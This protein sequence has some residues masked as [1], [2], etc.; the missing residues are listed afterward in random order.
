MSRNAHDL[1]AAPRVS[2]HRRAGAA[3]IATRSVCLML[4]SLLLAA[5]GGGGGSDGPTDPGDGNSPRTDVPAALAGT[6]YNG[7]V[8]PTNFYNPSTGSW[9]SPGYSDG[10]FFTFTRDGRFEKGVQ[11]ASSLYGCST[12]TMFYIRGTV[13]VD[14]AAETISLHPTYARAVEER[15]CPEHTSQERPLDLAEEAMTYR[16]G[17]GTDD[18]GAYK[19]WL[20]RPTWSSWAAFTPSE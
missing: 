14:E 12:N 11:L 2:L 7:N 15:A 6:W 3:S 9:G 19:L 1:Y 10:M 5:C 4:A 17:F 20:L 8:S 16:Y 18:Y 13:T